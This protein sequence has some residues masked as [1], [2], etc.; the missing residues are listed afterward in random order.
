ML[1]SISPMIPWLFGIFI[2]TPLSILGVY[3][4]LSSRYSRNVEQ[5]KI[6]GPSQKHFLL[7]YR[8]DKNEIRLYR[9]DL[10]LRE[11]I[12]SLRDFLEALPQH[13]RKLW[14]VYLENIEND[15]LDS[16]GPLIINFAQL[17]DNDVRWVRVSYFSRND[18][19]I[20]FQVAEISRYLPSERKQKYSELQNAV[21][22]IRRVN[23]QLE[24]SKSENGAVFCF[25]YHFFE[26]ITRRY[27][28]EA[29]NQYLLQVWHN[30]HSFNDETTIVAHYSKDYFVMY[31]PKII[32]RKQIEDFVIK[33][34]NDMQFSID[35]DGYHFDANCSIGVALIGE[36]DSALEANIQFA[37]RAAD[38]AFANGVDLIYYDSSMEEEEKAR[39]KEYQLLVK[40]IESKEITALLYPVISLQNGDVSGYFVEYQFPKDQ[41]QNFDQLY[42]AAVRNH[43]KRDFFLALIKAIYHAALSRPT[44]PRVFVFLDLDLIE[45][46]QNYLNEQVEGPS[47]LEWVC[48]LTSYET[49]LQSEKGLAEQ[50]TSLKKQGVLLG[51]VADELI[52]T[53][54]HPL[55]FSFDYLVFPATL[56]YQ[57]N[58]QPRAELVIDNI[59]SLVREKSIVPVAWNIVDYAQAEILK[60]LGVMQLNGPLFDNREE[61]KGSQKYS[62]RR[63][64]KLI[65]EPTGNNRDS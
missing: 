65:D 47:P 24:S 35:F 26:T 44:P 11:I 60:D 50:L 33:L 64:S 40:L 51:V 14:D 20:Y 45:T 6:V 61:R 1:T 22:F 56:T 46:M 30:L 5:L 18:L 21:S 36:F 32:T 55:L 3:L 15:E 16:N 38:R 48:V 52:T 7:R 41:F 53:V 42:D 58:R 43:I 49:L 62:V 17:L 25:Y 28:A 27:G 57:V 63:I 8:L 29:A 23:A 37:I 4:Y 2:I 19:N 59:L 12:F 31:Q 39:I 13:H 34:N 10:R 9:R 54:V